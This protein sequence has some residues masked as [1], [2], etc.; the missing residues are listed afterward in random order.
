MQSVERGRVNRAGT[1]C[2]NPV[3]CAAVL[4]TLAELDAQD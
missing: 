2:G 1:Y 3:A 4:A